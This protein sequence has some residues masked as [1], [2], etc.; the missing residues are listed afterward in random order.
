MKFDCYI[1]NQR[2]I[3]IKRKLMQKVSHTLRS[4]KFYLAGNRTRGILVDNDGKS[5][6]LLN[7]Y[8][9][10]LKR[11]NYSASSI[12]S[13]IEHIVRFLNYLYRAYEIEYAKD[14]LTEEKVDDIICSYTSYLLYGKDSECELAKQIAQENNKIKNTDYSSLSVINAALTGFVE[15]CEIKKAAFE[16]PQVNIL[17]Q[18]QYRN[19]TFEEK[20]KTKENSMLAGVIYT[21]LSNL[22][23]IRIG[24]LTETKAEGSTSVR[25][26]FPLDGIVKLIDV[27]SSYR[28]KAIY[29]FLAASG[30]RT[31]ECLQ[32]TIGDIKAITKEVELV[33]PKSDKKRLQGLSESEVALLRWKGRQTKMTFLIEPFKSLFFQH[34]EKY[35]KY[36]RNNL[37]SHRFIFQNHKTGRPYF[38]ADRSSRIK[39]FKKHAKA[40]GIEDVLGISF[41]SLR[42]SYGF[43]TLNYLPL[44]SGEFGLKMGYVKILM[45]HASIKSTEV[46]AKEDEELLLAQIAYANSS[47]FVKKN[48][49]LHEIKQ[50]YHEKELKKLDK[51]LEKSK[52]KNMG[53]AVV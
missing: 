53:A 1:L 19:A 5:Y 28:D 26:S 12:T 20:Q 15:F 3:G 40:T 36:E 13:Y 21:G 46:Y 6:P 48:I 32:L 38:L 11:R 42:H 23:K 51:L 10:H 4:Q 14:D 50:H 37:V 30:C 9:K 18:V 29:S 45:G 27:A 22:E 35:L 7:I 52:Q 41:H 39:Q 16:D 34:L 33:S 2:P 43:Y 44:P 47:I 24:I 31:H 25:R 8:A 17:L 49:D